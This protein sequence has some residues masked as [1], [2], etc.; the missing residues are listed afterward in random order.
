MKELTPLNVSTVMAEFV[1]RTQ[2]STSVP[3]AM[4]MLPSRR[5]FFNKCIRNWRKM[6][7]DRTCCSFEAPVVRRRTASYGA[8][9]TSLLGTQKIIT[10]LTPDFMV[11]WPCFNDFLAMFDEFWAI[12]SKFGNPRAYF[13][14][15]FLS[16]QLGLVVGVIFQQISKQR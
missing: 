16:H 3:L 1:C 11:F 2:F 12:L 9:E 7:R 14:D 10:K 6:T 13:F 5:I 15:V 4:V 8:S